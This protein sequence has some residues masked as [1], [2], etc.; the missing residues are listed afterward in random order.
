MRILVTGASG[1]VGGYLTETLRASGHEVI[2]TSFEEDH[3][4]YLRVDMS[5]VDQVDAAVASV[6]PDRVFHLAAQSRA[7]LSWEQPALTYQVNVSGTHYLLQALS[8][9]NPD[10]RVL[11]PCTS[12]QYGV[13][14]PDECPIDESTPEKPVSPYAVSKSGQES[15]GRTFHFAF[16]MFVIATRAFMHVGPGQPPTFATADWARQIAL[17]EAGWGPARLSVGNLDVAREF[18]DVRDVVS[19]YIQI[20]EDG[21]PGET[22]NVATGDARTLREALGILLDAATIDMKVIVDPAKIR[23]ADPPM[24]QGS[25]AKLRAVTGWEPRRKPEETL[26]EVLDWWR[27]EVAAGR[28]RGSPS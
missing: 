26:L 8:E 19:A 22:Y 25:S 7:A 27:A 2:G 10:A 15:V 24:L 21:R 1:F 5:E 16:G 4:G 23:P 11:L 12:D 14:S 3:A 9:R 28:E 18:G 13:V 20:L 17:A 6:V